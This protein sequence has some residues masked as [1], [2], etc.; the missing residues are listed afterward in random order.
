MELEIVRRIRGN[1]HGTVDVTALEDRIIDHPVVQRLRRIKQLA[2]L[3]FVFP[4]ATHSRF[5]HSLGVMQMAGLTWT[6][7]RANQK[8]LVATCARYRDFA[9]VEK[10]GVN[11]MV[12]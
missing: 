3:S 9:A 8:R 7:M 6:K 2:F 1:V 12:H 4:G 11:G 10:Q 5:E